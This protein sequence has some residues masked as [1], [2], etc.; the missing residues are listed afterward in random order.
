M[1][2]SCVYNV[3]NG[4]IELYDPVTRVLD[5]TVTPAGFA[6]GRTPPAERFPGLP[7]NPRFQDRQHTLAFPSAV[8]WMELDHR[9]VRQIF[10]AA[11]DDPVVSAVEMNVRGATEAVVLTRSRLY[12]VGPTGEVVYSVPAPYELAGHYFEPVVLPSN[13]NMVL[14]VGAVPG[15]GPFEGEYLEYAPDGRPVRRTP[16]P[17]R[18]ILRGQKLTQ[19]ALLGLIYPA[20]A[21]ALVPDWMLRDVFD[22]QARGY[23]WLFHR[24]V[25][26]S[27][28][29][30]AGAMLLLARRCGLG[31]TKA[32][33]WTIAA[34]LLG[35]A[36]VVVMLGLNE[37][38]ARESCAACGR[39][40]FVGRR[41]CPA[42]RA[43][44]PP[45]AFDGREIFEP[46]DALQ[47][48]SLM[49]RRRR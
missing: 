24:I 46:A 5:G 36:A 8:Y 4:V 34:L 41:H 22:M 11:A 1:R 3:Q 29:A 18:P 15:S 37:W 16:L 20:A 40:R 27:S 2:Y 39:R 14:F 13:G 28:L 31:A 12:R 9:R 33:L 21:M 6:R 44:P 19:T 17:P 26:A 38:P 23:A 7:L 35:P 47:P 48:A 43:A 32:A 42:C 45:P 30:A 10:T 49:L 25:L